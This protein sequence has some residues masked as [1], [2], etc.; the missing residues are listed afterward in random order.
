MA[1]VRKLGNE[2]FSTDRTR[3]PLPPSLLFGSPGR[4]EAE[5]P[6]LNAFT[7]WLVTRRP[8][9]TGLQVIPALAFGPHPPSGDGG[10]G[11]GYDDIHKKYHE[12][13][14]P[15]YLLYQREPSCDAD[16]GR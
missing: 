3:L 1:Q 7:L 16:S 10:G 12:E 5:A 13:P 14:A 6:G 15:E 4:S 8:V 2:I 9:D 11:Y